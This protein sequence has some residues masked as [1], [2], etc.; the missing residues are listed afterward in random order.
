MI[1]GHACRVTSLFYVSTTIDNIKNRGF[2]GD[3]Q[4]DKGRIDFQ[5]GIVVK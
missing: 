2:T 1:D 3:C 4:D 5:I